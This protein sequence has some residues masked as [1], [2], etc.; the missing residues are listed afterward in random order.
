MCS[1][2]FRTAIS[3]KIVSEM[4]QK[5]FFF[6]FEKEKFGHWFSLNLF[7]NENLCYFLC[8]SINPI[9]GKNLVSE[10][11]AKMASANQI[12]GCLTLPF[13]HNK[14]MTQPNSLHVDTNLQKLIVYWKLWLDMVNYG[15]GQ[16][17]FR[18]LKLS[19]SQEWADGINWVF[20]CWHKVIQ[21]KRW[22]KIFGVSMVKNG[23]GQS[24]DTTLNLTVSE[25]WADGNK[26][27]FCMLT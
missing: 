8:S 17:G 20:A 22:S 24:G 18:T 5:C 12:A 10:I 16:S 14:S 15:C 6:K 11:Q 27:I 21:I 25:K 9:L 19:L 13:L 3:G 7:Y 4:G 1:I 26:L 23:W 2:T